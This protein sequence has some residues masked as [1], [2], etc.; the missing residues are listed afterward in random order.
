MC[1]FNIID[2]S[3]GCEPLQVNTRTGF[4]KLTGKCAVAGRCKSS[5]I[6]FKRLRAGSVMG[7]W[8]VMSDAPLYRILFYR[9]RH[10]DEQLEFVN[11]H[12]ISEFL[13]CWPI[14][15]VLKKCLCVPQKIPQWRWKSYKILVWK[16]ISLWAR[17]FKWSLYYHIIMHNKI[18]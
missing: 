2:G 15:M 1:E 16:N 18:L 13:H 10:S 11:I 12:G 7:N 14:S 3:S 5:A 9:S 4:E 8:N 6:L 17:H